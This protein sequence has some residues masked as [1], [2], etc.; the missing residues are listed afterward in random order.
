M[1]AALLA[2][3]GAHVLLAE[4]AGILQVCC[5]LR[6]PPAPGGIAYFGMFAVS[7]ALQQGGYGRTVLAEA[8]RIA[9]DEFGAGVLEM[10]VIQQ[11]E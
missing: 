3:P 1:V 2:E 4:E 9:R 8:E 5:E 11:R 7:P 10:T 6:E